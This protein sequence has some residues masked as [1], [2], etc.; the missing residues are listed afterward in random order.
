MSPLQEVE[1]NE[2][3]TGFIKGEGTGRGSGSPPFSPCGP[4]PRS[5]QADMETLL[6]LF[7]QFGNTAQKEEVYFRML[8]PGA[9]MK[10]DSSRSVLSCLIFRGVVAFQ[11][12]CA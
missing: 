4:Q 12:V 10:D 1:G 5:G 7:P 2:T 6:L 3:R 11:L 9:T 8:G